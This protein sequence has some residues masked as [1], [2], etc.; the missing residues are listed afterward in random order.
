[1]KETKI[2]V[3]GMV[4][5]GCENRVQNALKSIKGVE[6]VVANYTNGIVT[7]TSNDE[8]EKDTL[9]EIQDSGIDVYFQVTPDEKRT[10]FS[11]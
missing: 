4:C 10:T 11:E 7:V 1:M 2:K 5:N 8:V 9:K 3:E 6:S